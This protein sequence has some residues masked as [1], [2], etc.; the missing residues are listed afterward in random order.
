MIKGVRQLQMGVRAGLLPVLLV[1]GLN[2][3]SSMGF[4]PDST[5]GAQS[6]KAAELNEELLYS[7]LVGE[8]AG[9]SGVKG[10]DRF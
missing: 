1:F 5:E 6:P 3:C 2:A 4:K 7:L 8:F 10:A 9:N